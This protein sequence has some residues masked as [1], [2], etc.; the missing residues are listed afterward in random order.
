MHCAVSHYYLKHYSK[1]THYENQQYDKLRLLFRLQN[2][3][4][5]NQPFYGRTRMESVFYAEGGAICAFY[6]YLLPS[7]NNYHFALCKIYVNSYNCTLNGGTRASYSSIKIRNGF[8]LYLKLFALS[9]H[10]ITITF[11]SASF[12][13]GMCGS[14][15]RVCVCACRQK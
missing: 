13:I 1:L 4:C 3:N 8:Y 5:S 10:I 15:R 2:C 6:A 11:S 14:W 12:W 7:N 9:L